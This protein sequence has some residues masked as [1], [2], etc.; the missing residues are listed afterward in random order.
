MD[1]MIKQLREKDIVVLTMSHGKVNAMDIE[2]CAAL[3]GQLR[4]LADDTSC[5]A[6]VVAGN[7]RVFSAGVD[8]KRLVNEPLDY[9]DAFLPAIA[10]LFLS[11][12]TFPKPMISAI[13]GHA[14][15]GGCVLA[16]AGDYRV[17]S[18][19]SRIGMPELRVGLA[20]PA[21][22]IETFRFAAAPS[23]F[24]R[25]VTSGV[26]FSDDAALLACL[27]DEVVDS[28]QVVKR[29]MELAI[30]YSQIPTDVFCVTKEQIRQPL[31]ERIERNRE[32]F[33]DRVKLLWID[34]QIRDSVR[35]YVAERL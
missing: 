2:F 15:A 17:I 16:S 14:L 24:Q 20:L 8:L 10:D 9:V 3:S 11:A 21:E 13:T 19:E 28:E 6:I 31:M 27:A 26:S 18:H 23:Y 7:S 12:V 22:G 35:S 30:Q 1:E 32:C 33:A 34:P 5:R 25:I 29:A 4:Q